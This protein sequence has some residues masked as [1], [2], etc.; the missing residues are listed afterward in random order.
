M[1]IEKK[2]K[3]FRLL[4]YF[5]KFLMLSKNYNIVKKAKIPFKIY[6]NSSLVKVFINI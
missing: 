4:I 1:D 6:K 3:I 5:N 2:K